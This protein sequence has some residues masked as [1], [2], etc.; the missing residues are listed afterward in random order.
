MSRPRPGSATRAGAQARGLEPG[1]R[2]P[3]DV[4]R[5][6][7]AA[8]L[9]PDETAALAAAGGEFARWADPVWPPGAALRRLITPLSDACG[10]IELP[11]PSERGRAQQAVGLLL[12]ACAS[13]GR[14]FWGFEPAVWGRLVGASQRAFFTAHPDVPDPAVRTY[15]MAL[16][17]LLGCATDLS[18][19]GRYERERL[20]RK[21]FG[22][23]SVDAAVEQVRTVLTGWGYR[24]EDRSILASALC[25]TLL[26]ACSPRLVDLST[27]LLETLRAAP[28][29]R[30]RR[31]ALYQVQRALAALGILEPPAP[32]PG[33]TTAFAGMHPTW[34][35]WIRRWR[36]TTCVAPATRK[37]DFVVL[38][39]AGRWLAATHPDIVEPGQ[40]TRELCAAY[41]ASLDR[42]RSGEYTERTV[43]IAASRRGRPFSARTKDKYLG[44]LRA[45]F[46]DCQ[47]WG[48]I[49]RRFDPG[50]ALATPR[51]VKAL[52]GPQPR[53][54]ADEIWAKLLWAGL[55]LEA[56][57]L[58]ADPAHR[59]YPLELIRAIALVWLFSGLRSD[60][61]RRLRRGCIRWQKD[62]GVAAERGSAGATCLLDV[63]AH[64]TGTTFT[65]P[66]DPLVGEAVAAW[67]QVRPAQ[68]PLL[69]RRTGEAVE[70]LFCYR[71]RPMDRSYI[72]RRLI[73]ILC[74]KAGVPQADARGPITS[75]RARATI[76]SQ[77]YNA[78]E[79][80]TLFELQAW[81]GHRSPQSTQHYARITPTTL[82]RA[83]A[84][85]G[86]F[87]RNVRVIEVLL[88]REAIT[89]GAPAKG[90]PWQYFDLGHGFCTYSFF[91]QCPHRM[92]C[93]RCDFYVPKDSTTTQLLEAR[94][95]LQRMLCQIPLTDEERAAVEEGAT[96]V[97]Q[98]LERLTD[99]PTP[100][101]PTPRQLTGRTL[102][103]L[104]T[105]A[106]SV[107]AEEKGA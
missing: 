42:A 63:P 4:A 29:L 80:M 81:L 97:E 23:S 98:L 72:N 50:R 47:E 77:L 57:D 25:E 7:R 96:A 103:V 104:D 17:Y 78:K 73:P 22:R 16:G 85:A 33:G 41:V 82:S 95:N 26:A 40:W 38:A 64:K 3:I 13:E 12:A 99:I 9:T 71:A 11:C 19:Y 48:W 28:H 101:G 74:Q 35:A 66:V 58:P 34:A 61:I 36:A 90:A 54:I 51:A 8:A 39:R 31:A 30:P 75:H 69:D 21:V 2:E 46:R 43:G 93:A 56:A 52:I 92:A 86:Y 65:K 10:V 106:P 67:E 83:Y 100:A 1:G 18:R 87:A 88:D 91:E 62:A 60:E 14:A 53:V 70:L 44:A 27:E 24:R 107:T 59:Y 102:P 45:F 15:L 76:A 49:P 37:H 79:P 32:V 20:A 6:D 89:S 84:D 55:N 94:G 5:Y 105:P 68:P